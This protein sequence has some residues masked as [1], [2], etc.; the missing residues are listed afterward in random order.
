MELRLELRPGPGGIPL[1]FNQ[2]LNQNVSSFEPAFGRLLQW[3]CYGS[4]HRGG[5]KYAFLV[6]DSVLASFYRSMNMTIKMDDYIGRDG[7]KKV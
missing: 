7:I 6:I 2:L 3:L 5:A 1:G 4:C